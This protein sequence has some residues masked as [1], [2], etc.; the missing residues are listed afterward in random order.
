ML[1]RALPAMEELQTAWEAK[2]ESFEY[3][4]YKNAIDDGLGKLRK[5]YSR[6]D[7]KPVYILSLSMFCNGLN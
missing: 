3:A 1:W 7:K 4:L 2:Q 5:S 6:I